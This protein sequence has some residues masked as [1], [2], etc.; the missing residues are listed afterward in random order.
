MFNPAQINVII[1]YCINF[2][3]LCIN[4]ERLYTIIEVDRI[5]S[6]LKHIKS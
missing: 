2:K 1:K 6:R 3:R 4:F 5:E